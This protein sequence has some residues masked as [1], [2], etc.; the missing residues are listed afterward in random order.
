MANHNPSDSILRT[1][2]GPNL[3]VGAIR[4][5]LILALFSALGAAAAFLAR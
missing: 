1:I 4:A 2:L 3:Q 5:I